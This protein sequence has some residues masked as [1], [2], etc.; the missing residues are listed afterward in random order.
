MT[1]VHILANSQANGVLVRQDGTAR[2]FGLADNIGCAHVVE[3]AVVDTARI[4]CVDTVG[5]AE[6]RVADE[7]VAAAVVVVGFVVGA[8]VVLL[9]CISTCG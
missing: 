6:R 4:P 1:Q 5:A 3:E 2:R 7:R 8:V 9:L